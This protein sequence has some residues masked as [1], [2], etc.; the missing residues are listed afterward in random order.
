MYRRRVRRAESELEQLGATYRGARVEKPGDRPAPRL[1]FQDR[2]A[3]TGLAVRPVRPPGTVWVG[4]AP[5]IGVRDPD[6]PE[7]TVTIA[8]GPGRPDTPL[9]FSDGPRQSPHR[10]SDG[11]LCMWC[12]GDPPEQC[13]D[14]RRDGPIV[15]LGLVLAHLMRE[16]WWRRTGG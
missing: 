16:E 1:L 5:A 7:Q 10:Y 12:P 11:S 15:L 3:S 6:L 2:I 9:V 8:F 13:W 14:R 4:F